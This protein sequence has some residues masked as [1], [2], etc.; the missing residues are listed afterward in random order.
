MAQERQDGRIALLVAKETASI[1]D[2]TINSRKITKGLGRANMNIQ[3]NEWA[4]Q[5]FFAG[6]VIDEDTGK[7]IKYWDLIKRTNI[8]T[9]GAPH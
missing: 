4:Y 1:P 9:S 6:V 2:L 8:E 5:K 3:L 7:A